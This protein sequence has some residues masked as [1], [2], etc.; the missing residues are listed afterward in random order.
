MVESYL[1]F[2]NTCREKNHGALPTER[3][4]HRISSKNSSSNTLAQPEHPQ[5]SLFVFLIFTM[6]C[7]VGWEP[8][9]LALASIFASFNWCLRSERL[10]RYPPVVVST[11]F[12]ETITVET[13]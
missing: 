11:V 7:I 12:A 9:D 3:I 5:P 2:V 8:P 1:R 6:V 10:D 13:A 4:P